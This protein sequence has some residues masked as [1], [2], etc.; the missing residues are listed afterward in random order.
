MPN[1]T[2]TLTPKNIFSK[3]ISEMLKE[4]FIKPNTSSFFSLALIVKR[5][6]KLG[7]FVLI[8]QP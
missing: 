3:L 2:I 7:V 5:K 1:P 8:T 6:M 4:G